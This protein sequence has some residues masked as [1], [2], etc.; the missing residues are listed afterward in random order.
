[1]S[2][3]RPGGRDVAV[4]VAAL[5]ALMLL[6]RVAP[7]VGALAA[8]GLFLAVAPIGPRVGDRLV[9]TVC[10]TYGLLALFVVFGDHAG[11]RLDAWTARALASVWALSAAVALLFRGRLRCAVAGMDWATLPLVLTA[12]GAW[13]LTGALA[14]GRAQE[15]VVG[16][17]QGIGWDHQ[18]HFAIFTSF[19]RL[20]GTW[21]PESG[22]TQPFFDSY[23]PLEGA[24]AS[25]WAWLRHGEVL[26]PSQLPAHYLQVS[27]IGGALALG[28]LAWVASRAAGAVLPAGDATWKAGAFT[29]LA[30]VAVGGYLLFGPVLTFFDHGFSNFLLAVA[31]A[32]AC[33]WV[34][35]EAT[36]RGEWVLAA[37]LL[38]ATTASLS[39]LWTPLVLM[40]GPAALVLAQALIHQRAWPQLAACGLLGAVAAYTAVWQSRRIAPDPGAATSLAETIG[41]AAGAI[42]ASPV[43]QSV[44]LL[45][46]G[47]T[48]YVL[49]PPERRIGWR[50]VAGCFL[51]A[52]VLL[53]MFM[54][55]TAWSGAPVRGSYYVAKAFWAMT[56]AMA[57]LAGAVFAQVV[58]GI[59]AAPVPVG[60]TALR[61]R[62]TRTLVLGTLMTM[63]LWSGH[64]HVDTR[65]EGRSGYVSQPVVTERTQ[66]RLAAFRHETAGFVFYR[67]VSAIGA[68]STEV[69]LLWDGAG[70]LQQRWLAALQGRHDVQAERIYNEMPTSPYTEPEVAV[71]RDRLVAEPSLRVAIA[72]YLPESAALLEPLAAEF[73]DRV[74]VAP[75]AP[76]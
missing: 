42:P 27:A 28:L 9:A 70:L 13:L 47:I 6:L 64:A 4:A 19:Y 20:G 75:I 66:R 18:S 55:I 17:L 25:W 14:L 38:T 1:L 36:E 11:V 39:L 57:P 60:T 61:G 73:G 34:A 69:P 59:A 71:L 45:L 21:R 48:L 62:G 35:I 5:A 3:W 68:G 31:L 22:L 65:G 76:P 10:L 50:A 24:M 58:L 30:G 12:L 56:L 54:A 72:Y 33:S 26:L 8:A 52:A 2:E 37:A 53:G 32:T 46:I 16:A 23:P 15:A 74:R 44:A 7:V 41:S 29:A 49:A 51:G 40:L 43:A 63:L 67:A